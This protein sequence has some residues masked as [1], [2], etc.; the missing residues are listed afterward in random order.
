MPDLDP[1]RVAAYAAHL[2]AIVGLIAAA[3]LTPSVRRA[4]LVV[5]IGLPLSVLIGAFDR[6]DGRALYHAAQAAQGAWLAAVYFA[7][8][9][10]LRA[11][12]ATWGLFCVGALA[13]WPRSAAPLYA[14]AQGLA[15]LASA[16]VL[17]LRIREARR[18]G[19]T[20]PGHYVA[21]VL[22]LAEAL[23]FPEM[24]ITAIDGATVAEGWDFV[25]VI[26]LAEW[27]SLAVVGWVTWAGAKSGSS[28]WRSPQ[29][30]SPR[31][32]LHS[33]PPIATASS[34]SERRE[35]YSGR[36]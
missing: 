24:A 4:A 36:G 30:F 7:A 19:P 1:L 18:T 21:I 35:G 10:S 13:W 11:P 12:A 5:A 8:G 17:A 23:V 27:L 3:R 6:D 14:G 34:A 2:A 28:L 26:R 33:E 29:R 9:G 22:V 32:W 15:A 16:V 31:S 20:L 25:R